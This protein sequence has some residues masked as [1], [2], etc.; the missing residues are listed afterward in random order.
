MRKILTTLFAICFFYFSGLA[1]TIVIT[2]KDFQFSPKVVNA[3]V[4]DVIQWNWKAGSANHTT[5]STS[6]PAGASSWDKAMDAGH[7]TFSYTI[8]VAGTYQYWCVPHSP[9]MAGTLNVTSTVPVTLISF[10]AMPVKLN[11]ALLSWVTT[12]EENS[13]YFAI[14][15]SVDGH[16]FSEA[17][18]VNAAG[19]TT[20]TQRYNYI[21]NS[22]GKTDPYIYYYLDIVDKDGRKQ[23]SPILS[24]KNAGAVSKLIRSI[25]PNPVSSM[26]HL[27]LEFYADKEG[28]M[29]AKLFASDGK[30][31]L[32][33]NLSADQGLNSGHIHLGNLAPG[34]YNI[35]FTMDGK[36]ESYKIVLQ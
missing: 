8:A 29:N 22:I 16:N 1:T 18:R 34:I 2:V 23:S 15:K 10:T 17:S 20:L 4:G 11:A 30:L 19:N 33:S 36:K 6:V 31:A 25:T 3:V 12:K 27:M 5:T 28:T 35:V 32:Q 7:V 13:N 9:N 24:V 26:G 21:D 14:M